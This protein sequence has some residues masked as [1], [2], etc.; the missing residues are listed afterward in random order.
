MGIQYSWHSDDR[1]YSTVVD[2]QYQQL[3]SLLHL[4]SQAIIIWIVLSGLTLSSDLDFR[5][6]CVFLGFITAFACVFPL[7]VK[8]GIMLKYRVRPTF[9]AETTF[10]MI[11]NEVV[12]T[13]PGAGQFPWTVYDRA[14]HFPDGIL[15]VRKGGIRWLP[16]AAL[17][18]GTAADAIAMVR[19]HLPVR[20]LS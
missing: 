3:P 14:V 17:T 6:K 19:T 4:R 16:D 12:I 7:L 13:G 2:H 8:R 5:T 18:E 20:D 11:D 1:Y 15:L 10:R 9:G